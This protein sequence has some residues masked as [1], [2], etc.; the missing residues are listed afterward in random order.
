[1]TSQVKE[2]RDPEFFHLLGS[3]LLEPHSRARIVALAL[4]L[5][6]GWLLTTVVFPLYDPVLPVARD[7]STTFYAL[8]LVIMAL[9]ATWRP[10]VFNERLL[11]ITA[12]IASVAGF[13][14]IIIGALAGSA[15]ILLIGTCTVHLSRS[16]VVVMT[17][18]SFSNL[19]LKRIAICV[20]YATIL[21]C[22]LVI[23][24]SLLPNE[25]GLGVFLI[26]P[27]MVL[28]IIRPYVSELFSQI[29]TLEVPA[30]RA[31]T[32]PLSY[33]PF[34][35]QI[36]LCWFLFQI[37]NG[38]S[39]SFGEENG[40]PLVTLFAIVPPLLILLKVLLTQRTFNPD[41]L[42][43]IA[44]LLATIGL[45]LAPSAHVL[46]HG[47]IN[48]ILSLGV[49]IADL[50]MWYVLAALSS[51]NRLGA[52][53]VIAWGRSLSIIGIIVGAG[54]GRMANL[55]F[56]ENTFGVSLITIV[57]AT[58]LL[59]Y[60]LFFLKDFSFSKTI[61]S[62]L[63]D[64]D[65]VS[66]TGN[67]QDLEARSVL[68]AQRFQLTPREAEVLALLARGRNSNFIKDELV[69]SRNTV[70]AHVKHIYQKLNIHTHQEVIDMVEGELLD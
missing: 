32:M 10:R 68:I 19:D 4:Y 18:V 11:S 14:L 58:A 24:F 51:R 30:N 63:P 62:V 8:V 35:H 59:A 21:F 27:T 50:V 36:F 23:V 70:K 64:N 47:V 60:V 9:L 13:A 2:L 33:L 5:L 38:Y 57:I 25:V 20:L 22:S 26:V 28:A 15:L 61:G 41:R 31:I 65:V 43:Y 29:R 56:I 42:F 6:D 39:L 17:G 55:L 12:V 52:V 37:V 40:T 69:V 3:V 53:G 54:L 48:N 7:I 66:H 46:T 45:M 16:W 44:I 34:T 1:M 49:V 67:T